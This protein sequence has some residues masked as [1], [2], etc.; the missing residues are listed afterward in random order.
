MFSPFSS[1]IPFS[2]RQARQ[3]DSGDLAAMAELG[4][5]LLALM[6]EV[7]FDC[8]VQWSGYFNCFELYCKMGDLVRM[9]TAVRTYA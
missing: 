7:G 3:S 2:P 9:M 6:Q 5:R 1:P 8:S 4:E